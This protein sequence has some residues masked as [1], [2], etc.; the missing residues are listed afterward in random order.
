MSSKILIKRSTTSGA[1][2]TTSDLDTGELGLN[3]ADKRLYTNNF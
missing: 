1:I 2:P 3:T